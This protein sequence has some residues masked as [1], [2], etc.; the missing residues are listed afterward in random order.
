VQLNDSSYTPRKMLTTVKII[1]TH[2]QSK[3]MDSNSSKGVKPNNFKIVSSAKFYERNTH[4][5]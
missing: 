4:F 3:I 2:T 5:R 1:E